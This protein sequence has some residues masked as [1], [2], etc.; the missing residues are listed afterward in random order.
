MEAILKKQL[1]NGCFEG[2]T[3]ERSRRMKAIGSK[4][5]QST[6]KRFRAI[7]AQA[8][9]RG[10]TLNANHLPGK[11]DVLFPALKIAVFLDGCFW[12]GCP[13]CGHVPRRNTRFWETKIKLNQ[14]R[15][16]TK[17]AALRRMGFDVVRYWEHELSD[18]VRCVRKLEKLLTAVDR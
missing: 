11:P 16:R 18:S 8:G 3:P 17:T 2:L 13:K 9:V 14:R 15:D 1:Q 10:W 7:L 12:H 5:G 4:N 6:E